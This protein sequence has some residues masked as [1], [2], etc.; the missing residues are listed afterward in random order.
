L[1]FHQKSMH[2][3]VNEVTNKIIRQAVLKVKL[4]GQSL[5]QANSETFQGKIQAFPGY[6]WQHF[7]TRNSLDFTQDCTQDCTIPI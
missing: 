6:F 3:E 2:F 1:L 5:I 7:L 4:P